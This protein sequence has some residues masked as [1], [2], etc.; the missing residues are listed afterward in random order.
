M[1][2]SQPKLSLSQIILDKS[3]IKMSS[4]YEVK[5]EN[6][7]LPDIDRRKTFVLKQQ[8]IEFEEKSCI[9]IFL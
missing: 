9:L 7:Y 1:I 2:A 5:M 4:I 8:K 3:M 6:E